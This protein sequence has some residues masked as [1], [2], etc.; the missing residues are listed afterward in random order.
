VYNKQRGFKRM[1]MTWREVHTGPYPVDRAVLRQVGRAFR[2]MVEGLDSSPTRPL[3]CAGKSA[4]VPLDLADFAGSVAR[5]A[6]AHDNGCPWD[7]RTCARIARFG[8]VEVL[9]WARE[10]DCQWN[11]VTC[12]AAAGNGH[13]AVL[14]WAWEQG[15]PWN[16]ATC[17]AAALG[18]HLEAG[19]DT[20][21]RFRST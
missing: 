6:W 10:H 5:L 7:E 20:R 17:S 2:E 21:S 9:Q 14:Q 8:H 11:Y 18:G 12:Y 19:A 15:C 1:S 4:G 16:P 13:L 3:P